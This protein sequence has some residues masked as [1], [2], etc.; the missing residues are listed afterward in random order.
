VANV[1]VLAVCGDHRPIRGL[2]QWITSS[3]LGW[4]CVVERYAAYRLQYVNPRTT[5]NNNR[6]RLT[7]AVGQ[8]FFS[9]RDC[10]CGG[11]MSTTVSPG[12]T[13]IDSEIGVR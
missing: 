11:I 13:V 2:R 5:G 3:I 8:L 6:Q 9:A 12:L 7:V 1:L 4:D 10:Y